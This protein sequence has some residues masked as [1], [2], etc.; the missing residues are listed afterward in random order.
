MA[1]PTITINELKTHLKKI[2]K[3]KAT[4]PDN[5][6][7]ELYTALHRSDICTRKL[8]IILQNILDNETKVKTWEKSNTTMVPKVKKTYSKT[9]KTNCSNGCILQAVHEDPRKEY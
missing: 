2:K 5:I 3:N 4:G 8:H 1:Y 6:K 9:V 7:G